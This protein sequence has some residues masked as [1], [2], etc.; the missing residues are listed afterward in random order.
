MQKI[1]ID[2]R[3]YEALKTTPVAE[4]TQRENVLALC[5]KTGTVAQLLLQ[6]KSREEFTAFELERAESSQK[7][8]T[9][10]RRLRA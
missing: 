9:H 7:R 4:L 2:G 1:T 3:T 10:L 5:R 6:S 8:F